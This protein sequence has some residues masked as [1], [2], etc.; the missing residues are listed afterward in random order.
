MTPHVAAGGTPV[1][2]QRREELIV[3]NIRRFVNREPLLNMVDKAN[4][5]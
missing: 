3:E 2:N 4:W 1:N 5:F